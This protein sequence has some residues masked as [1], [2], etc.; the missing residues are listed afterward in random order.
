MY[1][2][3]GREIR[4]NLTVLASVVLWFA[5]GSIWLISWIIDERYLS[6]LSILIVAGAATL[7]IRSFILRQAEEIRTALIVTGRDVVRPHAVP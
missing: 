3:Q 7:S 1:L 4:T 6:A 5:A 2:E